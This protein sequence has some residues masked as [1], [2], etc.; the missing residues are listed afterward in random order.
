MTCKKNSAVIYLKQNL[1]EIISMEK[2]FVM[3]DYHIPF[4][5]RETIE[6]VYKAM[7]NY[8]PDSIIL[9][10]DLIDFFNISAFTKDK[11]NRDNTNDERD[12]VDAE[13][14]VIRR[15]NP[16][17][18]IYFV[19]GNH[20]DRLEKYIL[21]NASDLSVL[22]ELKLDKF[23]KLS[24]YGIKYIDQRYFRYK[25]IMFSHMDKYLTSGTARYMTK[26]LCCDV[27][28]AHTHHFDYGTQRDLTFVDLGCLC[29]LQQPYLK[30]PSDFTQGFLAVEIDG[31]TKTYKPVVIK[32]HHF[33]FEGKKY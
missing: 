14:S 15:L 1:E 19:K 2:I 28:H 3:A 7:K 25:G 30:K 5:D 12:K 26:D 6:N 13:F 20:E 22:P 33:S 31:A 16:K 4:E 27:V 24:D 29:E 11:S 17:S 32:D 8:K 18:N 23:L 10:G 9:L 21:D